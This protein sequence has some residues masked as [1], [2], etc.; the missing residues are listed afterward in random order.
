MAGADANP[1]LPEGLP[2]G[3]QETVSDLD[4]AY[5]VV[6][7]FIA[8]CSLMD[9]RAGQMIARW[10]TG[11]AANFRQLGY[12]M[13]DLPF[14]QKRDVMTARL[15]AFHP[16]ADALTAVMAEAELIMQRRDLALNGLLGP[17]RRLGF[18]IKSHSA[19]RY[20]LDGDDIL[21][22]SEIP[23]WSARAVTATEEIQRLATRCRHSRSANAA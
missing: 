13:H 21:P 14:R 12:V 10:F 22:V 15:T 9:Y 7:G 8:R 6:G 11:E 18:A 1:P 4:H 16:E 23:E 5:A 20:I 17:D 2:E 3:L 19:S